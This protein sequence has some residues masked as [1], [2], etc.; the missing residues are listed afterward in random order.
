MRDR[1]V[2]GL[3]APFGYDV[4]HYYFARTLMYWDDYESRNYLPYLDLDIAK[5]LGRRVFF[6]LQGCD[7]R[8][9]GESTLRNEFTPCRQDACTLFAACIERWDDVRKHFISEVL[10][11]V[12]RAFFLN[13][14][15]GH[16][17]GGKAEF[18]PYSSFEIGDYEVTPPN[19]GRRPRIIHAPT[20]SAIKGTPAILQAIAALRSKYQFE[21]ILI[22]NMTHEQALRAYQSADV[23]IDQV[24]AGWYGGF[25]VEVMAMGKPVMCYLRE[26]DFQ[27]VPAEMIADM[28]I[29]NV[30]P[31]NL[32]NDIASVLER[33]AEWPELSRRSR[34]FVEK[35]HN[36]KAIAAAMIDAYGNPRAPFT[37]LD[38]VRRDAAH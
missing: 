1:L 38:R 24:L 35:W 25:A 27:F 14:E 18:L 34:R 16:F 36:P 2:N 37:L 8:L 6:T 13:P 29:I 5:A 23:V 10:P 9:A 15:L 28:P 20:D 21:F 31:D 22:Q 3:C 12:D 11:K 26:R 17:L 32:E 7:V 30:R 33:H 19:L 4:L